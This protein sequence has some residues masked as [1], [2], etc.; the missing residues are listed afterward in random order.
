MN[1]NLTFSPISSDLKTEEIN[2]YRIKV[3]HL[4][5]NLKEDPNNVTCQALLNLTLNRLEMLLTA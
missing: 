1:T 3:V 5:E 2:R 4:S